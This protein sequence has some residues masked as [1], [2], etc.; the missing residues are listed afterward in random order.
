MPTYLYICSLCS[1]ELTMM[2]PFS[3]REDITM[4]DGCG[5]KT[6]EL[7]IQAPSV[8]SI[9][10]PDGVKRKGWAEMREASKLNKQAGNLHGEAKKEIVREINKISSIRKSGEG[11]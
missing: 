8:M 3:E 5:H 11:N 2:I 9:A 6:A 7:T 4:C 1:N 10:L